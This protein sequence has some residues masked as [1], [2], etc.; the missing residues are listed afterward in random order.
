MILIEGIAVTNYLLMAKES[1]HRNETVPF[2]VAP[3]SGKYITS[4]FVS[5]RKYME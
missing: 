5:L 4:V 1:K 2:I 3:S